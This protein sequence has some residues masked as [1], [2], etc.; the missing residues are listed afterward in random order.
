[1][2]NKNIMG[3]IEVSNKTPTGDPNNH[4]LTVTPKIAPFRR[5]QS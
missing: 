3:K 1:M 5:R 2:K 4:F